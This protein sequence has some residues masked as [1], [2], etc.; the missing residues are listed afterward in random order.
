M[1]ELPVE[2]RILAVLRTITDQ[3]QGEV[4]T[5]AH[6][7]SGSLSYYERR[8]AP[9]PDVLAEFVQ[10]MG[11]PSYL[12]RPTRDL[13]EAVDAARDPARAPD[14]EEVARREFEEV[15][16]AGF[17]DLLGRLDAYIEACLEH[18]EAPYL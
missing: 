2:S 15:A 9:P 17:R 16:Y 3:T 7:P 13:I 8:K 4:E 6:Q 1:A 5:E 18:R 10:G 12:I 11:V 14:P